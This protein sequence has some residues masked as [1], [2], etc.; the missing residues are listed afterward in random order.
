MLC[1][2]ME[3]F[4]LSKHFNKEPHAQLVILMQILY[5]AFGMNGKY[6]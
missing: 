3:K 6:V 4:Y 1:C 5:S 2:T